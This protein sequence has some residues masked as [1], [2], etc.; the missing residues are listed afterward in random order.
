MS[1]KKSFNAEDY[2]AYVFGNKAALSTPETS[3]KIVQHIP[4][5]IIDIYNTEFLGDQDFN[6]DLNAIALLGKSFLNEDTGINNIISKYTD[7]SKKFL[8]YVN[9]TQELE[10][11]NVELQ[12]QESTEIYTSPLSFMPYSAL[13]GTSQELV[14]I[15]P[16]SPDFNIETVDESKRFIYTTFEKMKSVAGDP[17]SPL[18]DF[19]YQGKTLKLK[20]TPLL[21]VDESE[22]DD[23][24]KNI[25]VRSKSI[26]KKG[27]TPKGV[28]QVQDQVLL[29]ITDDQ[30][31]NVYFN[32][33]GDITTKEEGGKLAYQF[34]RDVRK[35]G[36]KYNV[37]NIYGYSTILD[38]VEI[39]I[40]LYKVADP[41][42]INNIARM[43]Q[44]EFKLLYDLKENVLNAGDRP[45]LPI[46][47]I[48]KGVFE[49]YVCKTITLNQLASLANIDSSVF[50]SIKTIQ[51]D[52][53]SFKA[54]NAD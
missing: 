19:V 26:Q 14:A 49:K 40:S 8:R 31:N 34:L 3:A 6:L 50:K 47:G 36:D 16:T 39:A 27:L 35:E 4:R 25:I 11:G 33:D 5:M 42:V 22:L 30:G 10:A 28:V 38:P 17:E 52:R 9:R 44:E 2:M 32:Q 15:D 18:S 13:S 54:G 20:P 41:E 43:Q 53:G 48:S 7:K 37:Y 24:V 1:D 12:D 23:Y 51:K 46:V 45:L 29:L 21:E